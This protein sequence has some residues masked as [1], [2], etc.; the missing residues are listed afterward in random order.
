[1]WYNITPNQK[2]QLQ[3]VCLQYIVINVCFLV[4]VFLLKKGGGSIA[5]K[6]FYLEYAFV[7]CVYHCAKRSFIFKKNNFRMYIN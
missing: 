5:K 4:V 6:Y 7:L 1:M 2:S 3:I